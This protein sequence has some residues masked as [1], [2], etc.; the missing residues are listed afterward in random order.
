MFQQPSK[1]LI[2]THQVVL[3]G[4]DHNHNVTGW[5]EGSYQ[6]GFV[7]IRGQSCIH[8][9]EASLRPAQPSCD[10]PGGSQGIAQ[11]E[12][13]PAACSSNLPSAIEGFCPGWLCDLEQE[14]TN[15]VD[16]GPPMSNGTKYLA[17]RYGE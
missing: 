11:T 9:T 15:S 17:H 13:A 4:N 10:H 3:P 2:Y 12:A 7:T 5:K 16:K 6:H 1:P 8:V 14:M